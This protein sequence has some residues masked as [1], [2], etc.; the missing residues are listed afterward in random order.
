MSWKEGF[1]KAIKAYYDLPED[2]VIISVEDGTSTSYC[3]TCGPDYEVNIVYILNGERH[4][5]YAYGT[6]YRFLESLED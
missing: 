5:K 3:S 6:I 2:A 4:T 1:Y